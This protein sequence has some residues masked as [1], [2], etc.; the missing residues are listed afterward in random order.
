MAERYYKSEYTYHGAGFPVMLLNFPFRKVGSMEV[1]D[2]DT[3]KLDLAIA[4]AILLKPAFLTGNEI[5]FLRHFLG[6]SLR[7]FASRM[8]LGAS[9]IKKWEDV[10]DERLEYPTNDFAIRNL[11]A[12]ELH[13]RYRMSAEFAYHREAIQASQFWEPQPLQI[14][15]EAVLHSFKSK[16]AAP[17]DHA[18]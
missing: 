14:P 16:Q 2:V 4:Q 17:K 12:G 10:A 7:E 6:H 18:S 3:E 9:T 11:A 1:L 8:S 13:Q 5:K 15:F